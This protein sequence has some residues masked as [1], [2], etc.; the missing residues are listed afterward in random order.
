MT[1][2]TLFFIL[3]NILNIKSCQKCK[4]LLKPCSTNVNP[5]VA[6]FH[7]VNL[8]KITHTKTAVIF[9]IYSKLFTKI[10]HAFLV[11]QHDGFPKLT[12]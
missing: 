7:C 6:F 12:Q 2:L 3:I 1:T 11:V 4:G 5:T 10:L 9:T 8:E